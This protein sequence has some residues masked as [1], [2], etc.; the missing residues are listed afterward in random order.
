M[1]LHELLKHIGIDL[2]AAR[3]GMSYRSRQ[4]LDYELVPHQAGEKGSEIVHVS[5]TPENRSIYLE[6][7]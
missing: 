3:N 7:E 1:K 6:Y 5:I 4:L 2:E